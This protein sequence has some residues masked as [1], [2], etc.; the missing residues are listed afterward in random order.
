MTLWDREGKAPACVP[1][2]GPMSTTELGAGIAQTAP[3]SSLPGPQD[4]AANRTSR[5]VALRTWLRV[6]N[7]APQLRASILSSVKWGH[8]NCKAEVFVRGVNGAALG[9]S[10]K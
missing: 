10:E 3:R 1:H 9:Q 4:R 7:P 6:G 8:L 2:Q 5:F